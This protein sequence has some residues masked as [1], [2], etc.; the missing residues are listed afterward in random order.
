MFS[1]DPCGLLMADEIKQITGQT[2]TATGPDPILGSDQPTCDWTL[3]PT[4]IGG[5]E[6]TL[7]IKFPSSTLVRPSTLIMLDKK[8]HSEG[9]DV[10][11]VGDQAFLFFLGGQA[12][13]V[14]K[15]SVYFELS[16][17]ADSDWKTFLPQLAM[18]VTAR[19]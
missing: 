2:V 8:F 18:K 1:G 9:Q 13:S 4:Y 5:P 6:E 15:G 17:G 10:S 11:G 19:L 16:G 14:V 3:S 7:A 12:I